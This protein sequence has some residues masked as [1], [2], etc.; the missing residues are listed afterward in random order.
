[1]RV[2][3]IDPGS[4]VSGFGIVDGEGGRIRFVD[5]GHIGAS[6]RLPFPERLKKMYDGIEAVISKHGP[7]AVAVENVFFARNAG[8][9]LKLGHARGVALLAAV[10]LH[11]PV[12]EYT[13]TEIKQSVVGYGGA[14]K[15][16]VRQMVKTLLKLSVL[17]EPLDASDALACAICH[18][19]S[20]GM[21]GA[22]RA[23]AAKTPRRPG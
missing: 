1:M 20:A 17:P 23:A 14:E 11:L 16:Q 3:G 9:A 15:A 6:S 4:V 13:P 19:H 21:K 5:A 10:N 18:I 8:S 2:L 12:F 22:I 7:D